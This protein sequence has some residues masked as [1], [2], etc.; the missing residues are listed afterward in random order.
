MVQKI[1]FAVSMI[2]VIAVV[3]LI[4]CWTGKTKEEGAVKI[5]YIGLLGSTDAILLED[6]GRFAL[7][8]SGEDWDYPQGNHL[9]YPYRT[10]VIMNQ[11][12]EQQ[13]IYYMKSVGVNS[14]N[15]DFYIGTHSHSDHIGSGDEIIRTFQPQK[16]YLKYYSDGNVTSRTNWW[17]NLYVYHTLLAAA[18]ETGAEVVQDLTEGMELTLGNHTTLTLYNT[19]VKSQVEDENANSLVIEGQ[20]WENEVL[21]TGDMEPETAR[22]LLNSGSLGQVD[23]LKLPHHGYLQNNPEDILKK[24]APKTAV[25]TGPLSNLDTSTISL[26]EDMGTDIRT[27]HL[28]G[29]AL[30]NEFS[31][32][33]YTTSVRRTEGGWFT[34]EGNSYFMDENG[35]P[36]RGE[37]WISG[38]KYLFDDRGRM[39]NEN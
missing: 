30:V 12:F 22:K 39:Q 31:P 2:G 16:V 32:A 25:V 14:S 33:G 17:D 6:N 10:G 9:L 20:F 15:L 27:V 28:S 4:G 8:D 18:R 29:A 7:V 26:L 37:V 24:F 23:I 5:H 36:Y 19:K 35:R 13:V 3:L 21:L 1:N 38:K 11:G 34:W